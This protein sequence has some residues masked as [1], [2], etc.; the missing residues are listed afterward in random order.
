MTDE[1][2]SKIDMEVCVAKA[3]NEVKASQEG[4]APPC[5]SLPVEAHVELAK[6][7]LSSSLEMSFTLFTSWH[8]VLIDTLTWC[9]T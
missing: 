7:F 8:K 3:E 5:I 9:L 1:S 4:K 2:N 6:V